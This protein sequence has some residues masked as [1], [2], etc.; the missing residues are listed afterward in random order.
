MSEDPASFRFLSE[1]L[2]AFFWG[3]E[4]PM[5]GMSISGLGSS[6][7]VFKKHVNGFLYAI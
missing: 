5:K 1:D 2:G 7:M 4:C 3:V 6:Q